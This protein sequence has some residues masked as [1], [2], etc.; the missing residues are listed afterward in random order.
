MLIEHDPPDM[1]ISEVEVVREIMDMG[2]FT[3][4]DLIQRTGASNVG[5]WRTV[6]KLIEKGLVQPTEQVK[7]PAGGLGS[8]GKP[9]TVYRYVGE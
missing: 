3:I 6:Q 9:S 4:L 5:V 1:K 8:R 7:P 2:E